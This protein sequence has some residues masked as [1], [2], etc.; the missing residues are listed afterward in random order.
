MAVRDI[1]SGTTHN[2]HL[3]SNFLKSAKAGLDF[4]SGVSCRR[5]LS[6]PDRRL[7]GLS[8]TAYSSGISLQKGTKDA[9]RLSNGLTGP[10]FAVGAGERQPHR[11]VGEGRL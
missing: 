2:P 7:G 10:G 5:H 1:S 11:V 9:D 6:E 4:G 8:G 3:L